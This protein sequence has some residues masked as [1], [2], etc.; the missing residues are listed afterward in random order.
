LGSLIVGDRRFKAGKTSSPSPRED[1][2][3]RLVRV[4]LIGSLI[5]AVVGA[6]MVLLIQYE[7][8]G[9]S[10]TCGGGGLVTPCPGREALSMDSYKLNSPTNVTLNMWNT[11]TAQFS[12]VAYYVKDSPGDLFGN[13]YWSGPSMAPN[14]HVPGNIVIDGKAF[15]FQTA[16]DY[17]ITVVTSR[18]Q[19]FTLSIS[20]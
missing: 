4:L 13:S 11:G 16:N 6:G 2:T 17:T 7:M 20:L 14:A 9:G 3:S 19:Q 8:V 5:G 1:R 12:L 15:T 10:R 18:N